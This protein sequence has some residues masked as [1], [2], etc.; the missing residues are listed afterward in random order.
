M[1]TWVRP[2]SVERRH[3]VWIDTKDTKDT[4]AKTHSLIR[5]RRVLSAETITSRLPPQQ[6]PLQSRHSGADDDDDDCEHGHA[7]EHARRV[8]CALGLRDDIA[9]PA[10]RAQIL[11]HNRA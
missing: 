9:E 3:D 10:R 8:E 6:P 2:L 7:G 1:R 4:K 5:A 11:S